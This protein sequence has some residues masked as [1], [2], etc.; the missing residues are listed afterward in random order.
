MTDIIR[1]KGANTHEN[2]IFISEPFALCLICSS[3]KE[4]VAQRKYLTSLYCRGLTEEFDRAIENVDSKSDAYPL[5]RIAALLTRTGQSEAYARAQSLSTDLNGVSNIDRLVSANILLRAHSRDFD[6]LN[7]L[8]DFQSQDPIIN[9]LKAQIKA[10]VDARHGQNERAV[11]LLISAFKTSPYFEK[12]LLV[13]I[14]KIGAHTPDAEKITR[15]YGKY[16]NRLDDKDYLKYVLKAIEDRVQNKNQ[17]T[18]GYLADLAKGF[19][20]CPFD[21]W[22]VT[23]VAQQLI[24]AG[25]LDRA[26]NSLRHELNVLRFHS[27]YLDFYLAKIYFKKHDLSKLSFYVESA[28][29]HGEELGPSEQKELTAMMNSVDTRAGMKGALIIAGLVIIGGLVAWRLNK[30]TKG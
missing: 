13:S 9:N 4:F 12:N 11:K 5:A 7:K 16:V 1:V 14:F 3:Q 22:L 23:N 8:L 15:K 21:A 29:N 20:L 10:Y 27:P 30:W 28:G 24:E 17:V 2:P 26:E 19:E 6:R 18:K 25:K